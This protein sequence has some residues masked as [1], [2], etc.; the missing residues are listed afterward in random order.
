MAERTPLVTMLERFFASRLRARLED[1]CFHPSICAQADM[2]AQYNAAA[3]VKLF[4]AL[5]RR[6]DRYMVAHA[7]AEIDWMQYLEVTLGSE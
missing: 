3:A 7:N 2:Y 1:L 4:P 5:A 6:A